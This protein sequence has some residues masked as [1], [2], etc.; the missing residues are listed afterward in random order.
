MRRTL[1]VLVVGLLAGFAAGIGL[2]RDR[3]TV[4]P[5]PSGG[6]DLVSAGATFPYPLLRRWFAEYATA[7]GVRINYLSVG[8]GEGIRLLFEEEV[9]FG[10]SDR[11]LRPGEL[12]RAGCGPLTIPLVL[13][14]VVVAYNVPSLEGPLRIDA[15][16]LAG[17]FLG[18][19]TRWN[20]RGLRG[21]N[22]S[23]ALADLPIQVAHRVRTGGTNE[24]FASYLALSPAWRAAQTDDELRWPVGSSFEGNEG[25]ASQVRTTPGSIGFMEHAYA[26]QAR[27]SV[28]AV[29]NSA[30]V[31]VRPSS[32]A[33]AATAAELLT[34]AVADTAT[35]LVT[36]R[37]A[38]AY[39]TVGISRLIAD[40]VLREAT[41]SAHLT[42]FVQWA[43]TD[44]APS[45]SATGYAP[46][47]S[48]VALRQIARLNALQPGK[49]PGPVAR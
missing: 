13:G 44:G 28:A 11:P 48:A 26:K 21:L 8:S 22:P 39:P 6:I 35:G 45:A 43:L 17:I 42:A 37:G 29:R 40:H 5:S 32:A 34:A 36:A 12:A 15:E 23:A 38:D 30:G 3:E 2:T 19:I 4:S 25:V 20:D 7:T 31:F 14:A 10:V 18:R 24:V 41:R 16:V 27:L 49:C 1:A 47:S 46:L 9:D 33:L